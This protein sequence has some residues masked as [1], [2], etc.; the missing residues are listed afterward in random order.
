M[1]LDPLMVLCDIE[2]KVDSGI[3][4]CESH[5]APCHAY[6]FILWETSLL[7]SQIQKQ[8]LLI[9]WYGEVPQS[10]LG[11]LLLLFTLAVYVIQRS[12]LSYKSH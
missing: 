5:I 3:I 10:L 4:C 2:Y 11:L 12:R 9:L 1:H 6:L 8:H 7:R